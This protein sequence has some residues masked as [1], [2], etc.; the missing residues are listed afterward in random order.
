M[1]AAGGYGLY[2][3]G[4]AYYGNAKRT[5]ASGNAAAQSA[6]QVVYYERIRQ[7]RQRVGAA[8]ATSK[9]SV[10]VEGI[11]NGAASVSAQ[12]RKDAEGERVRPA[13]SSADTFSGAEADNL[14]I[15][16]QEAEAQAGSGALAP[17]TVRVAEAQGDAAA[18]TD[19]L[20]AK[21]AQVIVLDE[22]LE[23]FAAA[24]SAL[25]YA[26]PIRTS[27]AGGSALTASELDY[28]ERLR[29]AT[30]LSLATGRL[31]LKWIGAPGRRTDW[32]AKSAGAGN[33][34]P[35]N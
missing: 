9:G 35:I 30:A 1:P 27:A 28:A 21:T 15:R 5:L 18:F 25:D 16:L 7:L 29:T 23:F 4:T 17:A 6:E 14:R 24:G 33:W 8:E 3:Y 34:T 32:T 12:A 10:E 31:K 22:G 20:T 2:E 26:D 13:A 11:L 19:A